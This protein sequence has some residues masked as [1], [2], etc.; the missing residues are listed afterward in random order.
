MK[1][2]ESQ[3]KRKWNPKN[4]SVSNARHHVRAVNDLDAPISQIETFQDQHYSDET[5]WVGKDL[6]EKYVS[7][8]FLIF[9]VLLS[10]LNNFMG[11]LLLQFF[12]VP[13]L[14]F[15]NFFLLRSK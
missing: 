14:I 11:S 15:M 8:L 13:L 10:K 2:S 6:V 9:F 4:G 7:L 3:K 12:Y 1:N 5:G